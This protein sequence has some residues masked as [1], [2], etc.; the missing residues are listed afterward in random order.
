MKDESYPK[1]YIRLVDDP[2]LNHLWLLF[3]NAEEYFSV[4]PVHHGHVRGYDE[5]F[6][7]LV[8]TLQVDYRGRG[9]PTLLVHDEEH[10][11][12]VKCEGLALEGQAS[13]LAQE[14]QNLEN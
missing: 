13:R 14:A 7:D 1:H 2:G 6:E 11:N 8:D 9:L 5:A 3:K 10:F 12:D 4:L